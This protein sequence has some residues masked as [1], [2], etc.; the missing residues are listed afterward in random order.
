VEVASLRHLARLLAVQ[1]YVAFADGRVDAAIE[2]MRTGLAFGYYVQT[3]SLITGLFGVAIQKMTL[4]EFSTH[5]DQ[6]SIYQCIEVRRIIEDF[7][8]AE[9]PVA[10]LMAIEKDYVLRILE[11]KRSHPEELVAWMNSMAAS[12]DGT[13]DANTA[14]V[15]ARLKSNPADIN[16][17]I[18]DAER[19]IDAFYDQAVQNMRLPAAQRKPAALDKTDSP[20]AALARVACVDPQ[21]ILD[22]YAAEE[23][24]L[25]LIGVHVLIHR[26]RWDHNALPNSLTELHAPDMVKDLFTGSEVVYVREGDRYTLANQEP[27][28][29]VVA[30]K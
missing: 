2:C 20:G 28:K 11:A 22:R 21:P 23:E 7:L 19:R 15:E 17:L 14:A 24:Q 30:G 12:D 16:A 6:L 13:P 26:Y 18:D 1:Q 5:L 27:P 3:D 25:H 9:N 8:G 10:R 4:N 29:P